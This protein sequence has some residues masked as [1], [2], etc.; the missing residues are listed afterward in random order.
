MRRLTMNNVQ[1]STCKTCGFPETH[2]MFRGKQEIQ[3][4]INGCAAKKVRD[5]NKE[6]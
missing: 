4:C 6:T 2:V 5:G 1:F 3:V